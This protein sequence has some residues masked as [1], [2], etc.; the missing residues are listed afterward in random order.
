[1]NFAHQGSVIFVTWFTYDASGKAW[2]L[3]MT[4]DRVGNDET[5]EGTFY[6]TIG[7]AFNAVPFTPSQVTATPVGTGRLQFNSAMSGTFTYTV[8]GV[9]Q[10]KSIVP[11]AFG[12][13]PTCRWAS[14]P[15]LTKATNY[16]DIWW[17][18]PAGSESGWGINFTHQGTAIFATWFTYDT[19]HNPLWYTFTAFPTTTANQFS[20]DIYR[21]SGPP[22]SAVPFDPTKVTRTKVGTATLNFVSGT[23]AMFSY[24]VNDGANQATQVKPLTRQIFC[25]PGTACEQ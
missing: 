8:N 25:P 4:A 2:W 9:T 11:Q 7:P 10:M 6:Q 18:V 12:P 19:A 21:T 14:Q 5:Y 17:A 22:F 23:G 13:V 24:T 15:N 16:T 1:M 20:G 3:T